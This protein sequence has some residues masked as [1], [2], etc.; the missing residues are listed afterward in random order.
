MSD[1]LNTLGSRLRAAREKA[2]V[3]QSGLAKK[4]GLTSGRIISN[5][6]NDIARPDTENIV[7]LCRELH[8]STAYLL[9]YYGNS[10]E[11]P[12]VTEFELIKKYRVLDKHGKEIVDIIV[13]KEHERMLS[14]PDADSVQKRYRLI[15]FYD[16]A[17]SAGT[18]LYLSDAESEN[19]RVPLDDITRN[20]D[21]VIPV[22]GDS[23]EPL[24]YDGD[25]IA[26][27]V[28]PI[29]D[30]GDIG[31]FLINGDAYIKRYGGDC[32]IS[33]NSKYKNIPLNDADS[34]FCKG[35]V[36]GRIGDNR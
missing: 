15:P 6:E 17:A 4:L 26:V 29:V 33:V 31:I 5:W 14:T 8:I 24:F 9:G 2:G 28:T 22:S 7:L 1:E 25:R 27:K 11:G 21:Y 3:Y 30:E 12:T 20:A 23:M 16:Y 34:V 18:G 19:I 36:L 32:L 35:L 10:D 13:N